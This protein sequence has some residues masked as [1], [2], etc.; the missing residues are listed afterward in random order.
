MTCCRHFRHRGRKLVH[1]TRLRRKLD[2]FARAVRII[3]KPSRGGHVDTA[4]RVPRYWHSLAAALLLPGVTGLAQSE[5]PPGTQSGGAAAGAGAAHSADIKQ[6]YFASVRQGF[7]EDLKREVV[8]GHF[9]VGTAPNTHRYYCLVDPKTGKTEPNGVA[10]DVLVRS[11]GM[12]GLKNA[13]VSPLS[14]AD[15]EQ[16]G[17]LVTSGYTVKG[18]PSAAAAAGSAKTAA[19]AGGAPG[20]AAAG[21]AV[22]ATAAGTSAVGSTTGA[23]TGGAAG[24]G[25]AASATAAGAVITGGAAATVQKAADAITA[26]TNVEGSGG[27]QRFY[28]VRG[29][30]LY[31]ERFGHGQPVLFLHGGMTFFDSTFAKQRDYFA[32]HR[33]VI[34][35]DQRGHGHSPDGAWTL[36]YQLMADDTAAVLGQLGLGPVDVVGQSD[37]GDIA[38]LLARDHPELVRR[39][40]ISGANL[41][42]GLTPEEVQ[43]RRGWSSEQLS[44]KLQKIS[45]SLPPSFRPDYGRVSP[46]GPDHWMTL[47]GKCYFMWIEPVVIE[48][49][50]LKKITAPVLVVAGDRDETPLEETLEIYRG[51][52]HGQLFIVPGAGHG[53]LQTR[54]ELVNPAILEFL[55][56]PES[57][58]AH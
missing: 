28:E 25:A 17:F 24:Q 54:P 16:K 21:T 40:V 5:P 27:A 44:A 31:T 38:L 41:R 13:A 11:D 49:P 50:E 14:C 52:P 55:D 6:D 57:G 29:A 46:D 43:Q 53:T 2:R 47:L 1:G 7:A 20:A 26:T 45:D 58:S 32:A 22:G 39:V 37:G 51:V 33:T 42:S 9:D 48:P 18:G 34:G 8:R 23:A 10:G 12:T 3:A 4:E 36:S 19:A 30:K 35:I 15:A 56:H